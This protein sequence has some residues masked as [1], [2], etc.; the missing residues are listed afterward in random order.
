M[1]SCNPYGDSCVRTG[2]KHVRILYALIVLGVDVKY[3]FCCVLHW[4]TSEYMYI[5]CG[6]VCV[7]VWPYAVL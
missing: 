2:T 6:G 1:S 5:V 7:C 3:Q 4:Y